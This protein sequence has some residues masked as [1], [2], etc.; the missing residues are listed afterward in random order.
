MRSKDLVEKKLY[1]LFSLSTFRIRDISNNVKKTFTIRNLA[2]HLPELEPINAAGLT[3]GVDPV[4]VPE[5]GALA[6]QPVHEALEPVVDEVHLFDRHVLEVDGDGGL[7]VEQ[8][9]GVDVGGQRLGKLHEVLLERADRGGGQV[10]G[11]D[12]QGL[13]DNTGIVRVILKGGV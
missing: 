12:A 13:K 6:D 4:H 2:K 10:G 9:V 1:V 3:D 5:L 11:Q 7:R 8:D